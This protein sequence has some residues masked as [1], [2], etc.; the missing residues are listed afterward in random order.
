MINV[1]VTPKSPKPKVFMDASKE[2]VRTTA[3]L[4]RVDARNR[5]VNFMGFKV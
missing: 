4:A 2:S 3:G 1:R 5:E